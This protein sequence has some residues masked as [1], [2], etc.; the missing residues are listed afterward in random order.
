MKAVRNDKP[1]FCVGD[2]VYINES[3]ASR[4]RYRNG[5]IVAVTL[6]RHSRTLDKYQVTFV[7]GETATFWDIQL[8]QDHSNLA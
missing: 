5:R 6:S 8:Q 1:R 7:E 2:A 3:I 4:Y